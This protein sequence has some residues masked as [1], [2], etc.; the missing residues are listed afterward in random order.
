MASR[1][2]TK[3]RE[4]EIDLEAR[5]R[6]GAQHEE[7]TPREVPAKLLGVQHQEQ[8]QILPTTPF[9]LVLRKE[10]FECPQ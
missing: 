10:Y 3:N 4:L 8:E 5:W 6:D 2:V 9:S 7:D 1:E